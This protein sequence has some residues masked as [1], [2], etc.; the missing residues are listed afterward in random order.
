[1]EDLT[2]DLVAL[3]NLI[4]LG[5]E[6]DKRYADTGIISGND[7][8]VI[9]DIAAIKEAANQWNEPIQ[10]FDRKGVAGLVCAAGLV[11]EYM[12]KPA[13]YK[14]GIDIALV[15]LIGDRLLQIHPKKQINIDF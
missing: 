8:S 9:V 11:N 1:M 12:Q 10:Q 15:K 14:R 2:K 5:Y 4:E 6:L 3:W 7:E 13:G